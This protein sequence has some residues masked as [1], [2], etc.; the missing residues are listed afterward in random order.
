MPMSNASDPEPG[1][2]SEDIST[3][4]GQTSVATGASQFYRYR[5]ALRFVLPLVCLFQLSLLV[6]WLTLDRPRPALENDDRAAS[7]PKDESKSGH[8]SKESAITKSHGES[9]D[10]RV[11]ETLLR[12]GNYAAALPHFVTPEAEDK[13]AGT[14]RLQYCAAICLEGMGR[15]KEAIA[16]YRQSTAAAGDSRMVAACQVGQARIYVRKNQPGEAKALLY[17]ILLQAGQPARYEASLLA[18]ARYILGLAL[19]QE[20]FAEQRIAALDEQLAKADL[21]NWPIAH[22]LGWTPS[23]AEV[24]LPA[25]VVAGSGDHATAGDLTSFQQFGQKSEELLLRGGA[26]ETAIVALV[27]KIAGLGKLQVHFSLPAW[28]RLEGRTSEINVDGVVLLDVVRGLIEPHGLLC[29]VKDGALEVGT[30]AEMPKD[31]TMALRTTAARQALRAAVFGD[32]G[33][34]LATMTYLQLGNDEASLG[35]LDEAVT[36]YERLIAETGRSPHVCAAYFNLG[37]VQRA[38]KDHVAARKAFYRVADRSPGHELAPRAFVQI[39]WTFMMDGQPLEAIFPLSQAMAT[40]PAGPARSEAIIA[41]GAAHLINGNPREANAAL[42]AGREHLGTE[43][44]RTTAAFLDALARF[45]VAAGTKSTRM[46]A[47]DLLSAILP[48]QDRPALGALGRLLVGQAYKELGMGREMAKIYEDTLDTAAG[49]IAEEMSFSLADYLYREGKQES[50]LKLFNS[51]AG[52]QQGKWVC[53]ARLRLAAIAL[54]EGRAQECLI[55]CSTLL[56]MGSAADRSAVFQLMGAAYEQLG[57]YQKASRCY[58][59][60][61]PD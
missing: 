22:S 47:T 46:D 4:T 6:G 30:E 61:M 23:A 52:L 57:D 13:S 9:V 55:A 17:R 12:E 8:T 48:F 36:W 18:E 59:G 45:R 60:Q 58:A 53:A 43:P 29:Q 3:L 28:Q 20:A 49:P 27:E 32:P 15:W 38:R 56:P 39:G 34:P 5:G 7:L 25:A 19:S 40:A 10:P 37:L 41:L 42:L 26:A 31:V 14:D 50:A 24:K 1:A 33:H 16:A 21:V 2:S 44:W 35:R 51:L 11:G 54:Q